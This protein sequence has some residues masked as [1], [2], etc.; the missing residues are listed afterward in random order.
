MSENISDVQTS[1]DLSA[2]SLYNSYHKKFAAW[3][4]KD[5]QVIQ[6]DL[7][8]SLSDISSFRMW[9][10]VMVRNRLFIVKRLTL[11]LSMGLDHPVSS[12]ELMS[13]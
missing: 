6:A 9:H 2:E 1:Y 12:V 3:L 11:H 4:A 7:D 8:L 5:R 13:L 10:A